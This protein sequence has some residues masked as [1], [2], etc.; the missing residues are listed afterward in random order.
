MTPL[1]MFLTLTLKLS[2]VALIYG[3]TILLNPPHSYL[4]R[5]FP[6]LLFFLLDHL[7]FS[8]DRGCEDSHAFGGTQKE[9]WLYFPVDQTILWTFLSSLT[10]KTLNFSVSGYREQN[11]SKTRMTNKNNCRKRKHCKLNVILLLFHKLCS[12]R[13]QNSAIV[14]G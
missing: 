14:L 2:P 1:A 4:C 3:N 10:L 13:N 7:Y 6:D 8:L 11:N 12:Q 9:K 5:Q